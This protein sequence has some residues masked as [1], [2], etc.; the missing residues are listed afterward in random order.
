MLPFVGV[1]TEKETYNIKKDKRV[2]NEHLVVFVCDFIHF[3]RTVYGLVD[4]QPHAV[5]LDAAT[6]L[7]TTALVGECG[8][9][10]ECIDV[11]SY[12]MKCVMKSGQKHAA[13]GVLH[14][15]HLSTYV[16]ELSKDNTR[17][18]LGKYV[19]CVGAPRPLGRTAPRSG[20]TRAERPLRVYTLTNTAPPRCVGT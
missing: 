5:V 7:S 3:M 8:V 16:E 19:C 20:H 18:C 2:F 4:F 14:H 6:L 12:G 11:V 9:P 10:V 17:L 1:I 13:T 15:G